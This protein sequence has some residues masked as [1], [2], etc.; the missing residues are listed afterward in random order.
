MRKIDP[1]AIQDKLL[2]SLLAHAKKASARAITRRISDIAIRYA[3]YDAHQ[4]DPWG[5][6]EDISFAPIKTN[7]NALYKVPPPT[8]QFIE[9]LRANIDGA[10]P[11]CGRDALGTIDHYLPK[12]NYSEFSF[13]S[14][15][16]VPACDRCNNKRSNSFKGKFIGERPLHPYFD[17]FAN[18]QI[19][20]IKFEPDW[21]APLLTPIPHG[22][23]GTEL[24][25][26]Q[27]HIDN[28]LRRA[29]IDEYLTSMWG[30]LIN[31]VRTILPDRTSLK[32]IKADLQ[33][34]ETYEFLT[35]KSANGWRCAFWHGLQLNNGA[36]RYLQAL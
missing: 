16:L 34:L 19:L 12:A 25:I 9:S 14:Q 3:L 6:A 23:V 4:G 18:N 30:V 36:L 15:N 7:L 33:E 35:G 1:P 11:M 26:V 31:E 20:T 8:L 2:L 27:W 24:K 5:V 13:Y 10:C 21:R 17:Y 32:T 22:V 28:V 29:G